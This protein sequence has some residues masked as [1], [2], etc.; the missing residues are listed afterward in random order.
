MIL[1][2]EEIMY[3]VINFCIEKQQLP[4][5]SPT[6]R[7]LIATTGDLSDMSSSSCPTLV[8]RSFQRDTTTVF[9]LIKQA[10]TV[11]FNILEKEKNS[12]RSVQHLNIRR[13]CNSYVTLWNCLIVTLP[14]YAHCRR[15][16]L[17]HS[18]Y[19]YNSLILNIT[20]WE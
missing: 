17:N 7:D 14:P 6:L 3:V 5:K 2:H 9:F 15:Y 20:T 8:A 19:I 18:N 16:T 13:I 11:R 4:W 1:E 10:R 12:K